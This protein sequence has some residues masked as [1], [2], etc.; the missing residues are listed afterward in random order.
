MSIQKLHEKS[1]T[2][3]DAS[4]QQVL[5]DKELKAM[6][7]SKLILL[8]GHKTRKKLRRAMKA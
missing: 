8:A 5:K 7:K 4:E 2:V 1:R 3:G 6:A